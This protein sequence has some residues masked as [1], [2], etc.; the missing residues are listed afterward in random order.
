MR[1][2]DAIVVQIT[3]EFNATL[4]SLD[5]EMIAKA[6]GIVKVKSVDTLIHSIS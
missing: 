1:G 6:E 4:V 2:M 3:K 5:D